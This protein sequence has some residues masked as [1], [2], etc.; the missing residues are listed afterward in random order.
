MTK[1]EELKATLRT[2][3]CVWVCHS[4]LLIELTWMN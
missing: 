1:L 2:A 3:Y 4:L